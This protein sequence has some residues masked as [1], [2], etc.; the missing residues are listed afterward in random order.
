MFWNP[1]SE[2]RLGSGLSDIIGYQKSGLGVGMGLDGQASADLADPFENMR[3]G[4][5]ALRMRAQSAKVMQPFDVLKLHT[6]ETARVLH[7]DDQVG[8]LKAG[9]WA[10]FLVVDPAQMDT[11]PVFDAYATLIFSCSVA[12]LESVWIGG[13]KEVERG[14]LLHHDFAKVQADT[15]ARVA[16]L[17]KRFEAKN[18]AV[19]K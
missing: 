18:A 3:L 11:G 4:L 7:L 2:G 5:Y 10:D 6:I 19:K 13:K 12:N 8:S 17:L 14:Q 16:A 9:K 15:H 1:L